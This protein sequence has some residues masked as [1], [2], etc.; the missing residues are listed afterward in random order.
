MPS[1]LAPK[2]TNW[3][4]WYTD[5]EGRNFEHDTTGVQKR[6]RG[7]FHERTSFSILGEEAWNL[8]SSLPPSFESP[9]HDALLLD[10]QAALPRV[11]QA[12]ILAITA[13]EVRIGTALHYLSKEKIDERLWSW[14][15]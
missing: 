6:G 8:I 7:G 12:I 4:L 11:G 1:L 3:H 13:I 9:P 10:A 5:D 14:I 15:N 2:T